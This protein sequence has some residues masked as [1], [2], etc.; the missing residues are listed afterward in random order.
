M[1]I[2]FA[3]HILGVVFWAGGLIV[4]SRILRVFTVQDA[5]TEN[6]SRL[7]KACGAIWRGFAL[8]GMGIVLL[9]GIYQ[10]ILGGVGVYMKQGWFHGKLTAIMALVGITVYAGLLVARIS[11]G[12]VVSRGALAFLHGGTSALLAIILFLVYVGRG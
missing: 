2:S 7:V 12:R 10:T 5:E 9:S 3:F 4:L 6:C 1:N 11:Q 8:P